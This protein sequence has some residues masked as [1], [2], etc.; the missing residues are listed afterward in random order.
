MHIV[1]VYVLTAM[2]ALCQPQQQDNAP[3]VAACMKGDTIVGCQELLQPK[4]SVDQNCNKQFYISEYRSQASCQAQ[5]AKSVKADKSG[6]DF[7][8]QK[9]SIEQ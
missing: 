4:P 2:T 9:M 6:A 5:L 8:C 1:T 7:N 3:D